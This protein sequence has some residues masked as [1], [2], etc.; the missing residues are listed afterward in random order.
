MLTLANQGGKYA[1]ARLERR[2][3]PAWDLT[4]NLSFAAHLL[5][6]T[7]TAWLRGVVPNEDRYAVTVAE[8]AA[9]DQRIAAAL[10][11]HGFAGVV[12][13]DGTAPTGS[14]PAP[15]VERRAVPRPLPGDGGN[16][17]SA[18]AVW[19]HPLAEQTGR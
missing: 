2:A 6:A 8:R 14:A 5:D 9:L 13:Q 11:Q 12:W 17:Q 10:E 19:D 1:P 4:D 16:V 7:R 18:G 15:V 3:A